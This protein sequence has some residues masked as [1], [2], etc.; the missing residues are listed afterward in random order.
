MILLCQEIDI[1]IIAQYSPLHAAMLDSGNY[2][3]IAMC[4]YPFH[5]LVH[6]VIELVMLLL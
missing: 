1:I 6:N 3:C 5:G 4:L 2:I